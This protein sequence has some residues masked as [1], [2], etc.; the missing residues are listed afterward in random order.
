M[1]QPAQQFLHFASNLLLP[2]QCPSCHE[3]VHR[4][5]LCSACWAHLKRITPPSCWQ[6]GRGFDFDA[7]VSRCG[8]CLTTPP[9]FDR[10]AAAL[11][12]TAMSKRLI[13][14]LKY[15]GRHDTTPALSQMMASCGG[16]LLQQADWI[17]PLPLHWTR[18]WRR[19][20]N[21][22]AE[23]ARAVMRV[24]GIAK[25]H[26]RPDLLLR[27]KRTENQG[28]KTRAQRFENMRG[29]FRTQDPE[30]HIKGAKILVIDDV[31]T[32]G[33][34]LS[35]ASRCLKRAGAKE[36]AILVAARVG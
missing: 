22:S 21:Q 33:A 16:A 29:A 5:G 35:S 27:I 3:L 23:L 13:L 7:G 34:S 14:G 2:A 24:A 12:Y 9:D 18:H 31:L 25:A 8:K 30:A 4:A 32:T 28:H 20:Y 1:K 19:G 36:V 17:I 15:G 26:Y 10:G 6:C 11:R